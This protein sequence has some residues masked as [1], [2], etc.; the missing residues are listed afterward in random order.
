MGGVQRLGAAFFAAF[1]TFVL[2]GFGGL[3]SASPTPA[4][5][6]A[7]TTKA[8]A[9]GLGL[10]LN[11]GSLHVNVDVPLDLGGLLGGKKSPIPAPTMSAPVP[12]TSVPPTRAAASHPSPAGHS[13]TPIAA[14]TASAYPPTSPHVSHPPSPPPTTHPH[15]PPAS[16]QPTKK[17]ADPRVVFAN[18]DFPSD[19][20]LALIGLCVIC[21][22]GVAF[23]V[24][25]S[26]GRRRL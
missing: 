16:H 19:G 9:P 18:G 8:K 25:L 20:P 26:G 12:P 17:A 15:H 10:S 3:A 1:L 5:T 6:P 11:L 14:R 7:I 13:H 21:G 24:R 4:P 23:V 22:V 2:T